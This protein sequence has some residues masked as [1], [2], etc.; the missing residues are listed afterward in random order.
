V[1]LVTGHAVLG[2]RTVDD[3][4]AKT[5]S[6]VAPGTQLWLGTGEERGVVGAVGVVAARALLDARVFVL[7]VEADP[8]GG[9]AVEAQG[10]L[11]LLKPE[12]SHEAVGAVARQAVSLGQ[13]RVG[14]LLVLP[15]LR[16]AFGAGALR[17]EAG[18]SPQLP[19]SGPGIQR[20][21]GQGGG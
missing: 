2:R 17:L 12:R 13:G 18:S 15:D 1:G 19:V 9:M 8:F 16:V 10:R 6:R 21:D 11:L 5:A 20:E 14:H 4:P 7:R 3:G